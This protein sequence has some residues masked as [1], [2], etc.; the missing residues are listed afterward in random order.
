MPT[1]FSRTYALRLYYNQGNRKKVG[2]LI[3]QAFFS[4]SEIKGYVLKK[5]QREG[6]ETFQV[7]DYPPAFAPVM[8]EIIKTFAAQNK[9]PPYHPKKKAEKKQRKRI[10]TKPSQP[11]YST[12]NYKPRSN[13]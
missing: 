2:D 13:G 4:Q 1:V 7:L 12:K 8:D 10:P 11:L 6:K 3:R 9:I 5:Q